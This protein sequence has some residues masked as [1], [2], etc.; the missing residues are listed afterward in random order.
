MYKYMVC[1]LKDIVNC[2]GSLLLPIFS[3]VSNARVIRKYARKKGMHIIHLCVYMSN[4]VSPL[5]KEKGSCDS[6]V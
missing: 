6:N 3:K 1:V 4:M 2:L 5:H